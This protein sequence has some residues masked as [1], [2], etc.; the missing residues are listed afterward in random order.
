MIAT[1][2][3]SDSVCKRLMQALIKEHLTHKAR[4]STEILS[5]FHLMLKGLSHEMDLA[6]DD[7][8]GQF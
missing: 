8:H 7:M 6:F 2:R 3:M 5:Y 1:A 4:G